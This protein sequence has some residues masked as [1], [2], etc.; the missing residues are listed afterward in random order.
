MFAGFRLLFAVLLFL[1]AY[2]KG[3][4]KFFWTAMGFILGPVALLGI[5]VYRKNANYTRAILNGV[6]GI[7]AGGLL[8]FLGWLA[9]GWWLPPQTL[10]NSV[11]GAD[12]FWYLVFPLVSVSIGFIVFCVTMAKTSVDGPREG[13]RKSVSKRRR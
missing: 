7:L 8:V 6:S 4:G 12:T 5:L 2:K 3:Y 11:G 1:I 10:E 9:A 13:V